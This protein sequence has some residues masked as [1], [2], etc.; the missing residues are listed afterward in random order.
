[1]KRLIILISLAV[2]AVSA[3]AQSPSASPESTTPGAAALATCT[4]LAELGKASQ[5]ESPG[6]I[7]ESIYRKRLAQNPRDAEALVGTARALSVCILPSAGFMAQGELSSEALGL[8]DK[9]LEID[10]ANWIARFVLASISDRSPAFLGRGK[11]AAK[12]YDELLRMQGDRTDNPLFAGVFAARGRQL[13]REGQ[14]DSARALWARGARLF[15]NDA[16]LKALTAERSVVVPPV[17]TIAPVEVVASATPKVALPSVK[18]V[19]RSEVLMTA[20]GAADILQAVQMQP[21]ATRVTEGG[22]IYTRGGDVGETSIIVNGG[23]LLGLSRFEG[24]NGSMFGAIEPFVVK[25]VRY[26]SGG[27]SARHGNALSGVL[28]IETDGRPRERQTRAGLSLVQ[29]SGTFRGPITSKAGGWVSS[30]VSHTGALLRIHGRTD[31]FDGA[32][33]S[34][35]MIGSL[36]VNPTQLSEARATAIVERDASSRYVTAAGWRGS[37]DSRGDT[38]AILVSSRWI[39]SSVPLV[40]RGSFAGTTR[41]SDWSFGVLSRDREEASATT[42]MDAEWEASAG[43]MLRAGIEHAAHDRKETGTIPTS[44][45]VAPGAP[46]RTLD[47]LRSSANQIGAYAETEF[48]SGANSFIVGIRADR[49]PGETEATVDPRLALSRRIGDWTARL[50]GGVFHQGR[51]HG[52]AAIPDAGAP[53]GL[54]RSAQHAV[55]GVERD[56]A[57]ILF[58][59]EAFTKRYTDYRAFGAGPEISESTARGLD[60]LAQRIAG[61]VTG[62]VGYSLL[63]AQSRLS[64]GKRVRSAF[65]VRHSATASLTAALNGNWS[66]GTTARYGSGAPRTPIIGGAVTVD[67]RIEPVYGK[68]MSETLPSYAR[69]DARLMRY[70]RTRSFLLTIFAE[71][72]N[73]TNRG[74]VATFTYDPTY[75]SREP[76][77]TFFARR[78]IVLGGEIMFR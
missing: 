7:A 65:D 77:H 21:G 26:S 35:E 67:G 63:D 62:F 76:V 19:T 71:V 54:P 23:R 75:T 69:L 57:P 61:T 40:L 27:F 42:R 24:L 66:V 38:R 49:L 10:P 46:L 17:S 20:G 44:S 18:A 28:E 72:L 50:S 53:S 48:S 56:V 22:D 31:E 64:D 34:E 4:S 30:R 60:M 36:I 39:S 45:S 37:F 11:R 3:N 70:I 78:T 16:A 33:H 74:N 43:A 5:A 47:D 12:E 52:D 25:T 59:A 9:A 2:G 32:P 8:L 15:P 41:S 13:S 14:L 68:L 51:W 6:K 29:A 73:V 55:L 1:M 58:R